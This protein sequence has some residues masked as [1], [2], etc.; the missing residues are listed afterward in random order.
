MNANAPIQPDVIAL[1]RRPAD[2]ARPNLVGM[3]RDGLAAALAAIGTPEAQVAMRTSQVW[4]WL[5]H[6]GARDFAAMSN[7]SRAVSARAWRRP[8]RSSGRRW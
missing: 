5:Y 2:A 7:L 3:S 4:Q 6:R 1:P 8:S